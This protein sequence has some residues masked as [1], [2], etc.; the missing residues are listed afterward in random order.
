MKYTNIDPDKL[1]KLR[2]DSKVGG[3]KGEMSLIT[4]GNMEGM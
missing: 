2:S 1:T 4:Q 3:Y